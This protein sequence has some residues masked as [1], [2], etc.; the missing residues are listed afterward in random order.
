MSAGV[1]ELQEALTEGLAVGL[2]QPPVGEGQW[3]TVHLLET[4]QEHRAVGVREQPAC[5]VDLRIGA[6]PEEVPV[7]GTVMDGA[8]AEAVRDGRVTAVR[9]AQMWLASSKVGSCNRHT[10]HRLEYATR[11]CPRNM[12]WW[13]RRRVSTVTYRRWAESIVPSSSIAPTLL[14]TSSS[15]PVSSAP[16]TLTG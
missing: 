4:V 15:T 13:R 3:R 16:A 1:A 10:A 8:E 2:V 5:D 11:T 7:V 12:T 9:I 14:L 6:D